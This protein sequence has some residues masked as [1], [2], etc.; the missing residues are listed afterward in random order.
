MG[1]EPHVLVGE[2]EV[3]TA[4]QQ[5]VARD[6]VELAR[7]A[8]D[9]AEPCRLAHRHVDDEI[10]LARLD[11][12]DARRRILDDLIDHPL[13]LRLGAPV[14]VEALEH[15]ARIELVFDHAIG[16]RADRL[17][18]EFV[19]ADLLHVVL[20]HDIAAEEGEPLR[21]G[22]HRMTERDL[23]VVG[24]GDFDVLDLAP[25]AADVE[26]EIG[27]F[28]HPLIEGV[29]EV[30]GGQLV[31]VLPEHVVAQF[32]VHAQA[33]GRRRPLLD[34][35]RLE[36]EIGV[37]IE[38]LI[39]DRLED[40]LGVRGEALVRVPGRHVAGPADDHRV[41]RRRK[42]VPGV[43]ARRRRRRSKPANRLPCVC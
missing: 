27:V 23:A 33:V 36:R 25:G 41:H 35:V 29:A 14:L 28:A 2:A 5:D 40:G 18:A 1:G 4:L 13:D 10:G 37:L 24:R 19:D 39:V 42:P 20:R 38:R 15:D 7:Q 34:D 22:R 12:G 3:V 17:L 30:L 31:A 32:D 6:R 9:L 11:R 21:R 16:A 26:L 43:A 8:G